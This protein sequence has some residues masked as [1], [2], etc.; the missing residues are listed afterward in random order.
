M[1]TQHEY[2]QAGLEAN[3]DD[4]AYRLAAEYNHNR[5]LA[6]TRDAGLELLTPQAIE[7]LYQRN[8]NAVRQ[9][10]HQGR[11]SGMI[12]IVGTRGG[13]P[14][15]MFLLSDAAVVW[16]TP[17]E[18][19]PCP[20]ARRS[21]ADRHRRETMGNPRWRLEVTT[22]PELLTTSELLERLRISRSTLYR[23]R[24]RGRGFPE[25]IPGLPGR[26]L[27]LSADVDGWLRGQSTLK[28]A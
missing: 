18:K 5:G 7:R 24:A 13:S 14:V 9:A 15:R 11:I 17:D 23:L 2:V 28:S 10:V 21:Q 12:E 19:N 16:G 26:C 1:T 25:P 27:W 22:S 4:S 6:E 3:P 8:P 20:N